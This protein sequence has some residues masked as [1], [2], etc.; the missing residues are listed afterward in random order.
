MKLFKLHILIVLFSISLFIDPNIYAKSV[1]DSMRGD[2]QSNISADLPELVTEKID[3]ISLTK[4]IIII[5]N[6]NNAYNKGDFITLT[7]A[8]Q[9]IS[10]AIVAKTD[11]GNENSIG[12]VKII[13]IYSQELWE[14]LE[15]GKDIEIIRGDDSHICNKINLSDS[16]EGSI[17]NEEDLYLMSLEDGIDLED[18]TKRA[19]KTDNIL[20]MV[21]NFTEG[22]NNDG[23][24]VTYHHLTGMWSY[25]IHDNFWVEASYGQKIVKDYPAPIVD[26]RFTNFTIRIKYTVE[27]PFYS[28]IQPYFGYQ[29]IGAQS[30]GAGI[31]GDP[32]TAGQELEMV[33]KL[34]KNTLILGISVLRRLVPG[35]FARLDMGSDGLVAG[36][37]LEF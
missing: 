29:I 36:I 2:S 11:E 33:E 9:C 10:R 4:R 7:T 12:A 22:L 13:K 17:E 23:S 20:S 3:K 28:Y 37:C 18:D 26:T 15:V 19:I 32:A 25:Q 14:Q 30:P 8:K 5:T 34:K 1:V 21:L 24:A 6:D 31:N 16:G 27:A 35:W